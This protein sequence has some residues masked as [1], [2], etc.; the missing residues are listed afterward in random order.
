MAATLS[1][2]TAIGNLYRAPLSNTEKTQDLIREYN[3]SLDFINS[4]GYG[5]YSLNTL[6]IICMTTAIIGMVVGFVINQRKGTSGKAQRQL[7]SHLSELQQQQQSYQTEVTEHFQ[8]TAKLLDQLTNSYRDVHNHLAEGAH[9]LAG[10]TVSESLQMI[11]EDKKKAP[12]LE[13]SVITPPLDYAPKATPHDK[14]MLNEEFGFE[15][16]LDEGLDSDIK[17]G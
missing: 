3:S 11:P 15:G 13:G 8:E 1:R 9:L 10:E 16:K 2:S 5:V 4:G 14:G 12:P 7:E 17:T 6:L